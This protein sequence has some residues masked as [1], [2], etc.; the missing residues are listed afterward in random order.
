MSF[1]YSISDFI[2]LSA[3]CWKLYKKC[4]DAPEDFSEF[5]GEVGSLCIILNGT[6]RLFSEQPPLDAEEAASLR[7]VSDGVSVLLR[8]LNRLLTRST[9]LGTQS[10]RLRDRLRMGIEDKKALRL[11]VLSQVALLN[12]FNNM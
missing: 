2:T 7:V 6:K 3:T 4:K 11:R 10:K 8:D 9:S 1:G 5:S 12:A